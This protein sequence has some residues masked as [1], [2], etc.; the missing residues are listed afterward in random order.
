MLL[1]FSQAWPC[2]G[3]HSR[4]CPTP[5]R[6]S[7]LFWSDLGGPAG[8]FWVKG[9]FVCRH[10]LLRR[11]QKWNRRRPMSLL[12]QVDRKGKRTGRLVHLG[13][14]LGDIA[15][16]LVPPGAS[17]QTTVPCSFWREMPAHQST[18]V[19]DGDTRRDEGRLLRDPY[20]RPL[21]QLQ[22]NRPSSGW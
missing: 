3:L 19:T 14:T 20:A 18:A 2:S 6:S 7:L 1:F 15:A 12:L 8:F 11:W 10:G 16:G 21:M 22:S 17:R 5:L 4:T 9:A 13:G